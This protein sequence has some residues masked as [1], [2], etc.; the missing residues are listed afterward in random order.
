M[1]ET[2]MQGVAP[3]DLDSAV[4]QLERTLQASIALMKRRR[5]EMQRARRQSP[6]D[7]GADEGRRT[8]Q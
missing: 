7:G 6:R 5:H 8:H 4:A 2:S 3:Q 1:S